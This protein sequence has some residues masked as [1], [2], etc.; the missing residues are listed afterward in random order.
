MGNVMY[1]ESGLLF[2]SQSIINLRTK[3]WVYIHSSSSSIPDHFLCCNIRVPVTYIFLAPN[4]S[5]DSD[6]IQSNA[7]PYPS[8]HFWVRPPALCYAR[9]IIGRLHSR[10]EIIGRLHS[11]SSAR[12]FHASRQ[13]FSSCWVFFRGFKTWAG[14]KRLGTLPQ[15]ISSSTPIRTQ[16]W[17]SHLGWTWSLLGP[18]RPSYPATAPVS[19]FVRQTTPRMAGSICCQ[20]LQWRWQWSL[21]RRTFIS[22]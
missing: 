8:S 19:T 21:V 22:S 12:S 18:Q 3:K 10:S 17:Q 20:Y 11:W 15:S 5:L 4:I 14:S 6:K 1:R 9:D 7:R 16:G 2:R 13:L